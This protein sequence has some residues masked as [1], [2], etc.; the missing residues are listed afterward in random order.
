MTIEFSTT[1]VSSFSGN[2]IEGSFTRGVEF[3]QSVI[4][5]VPST[6]T[7]DFTITSISVVLIGE[8]DPITIAV[9]EPT[10][11]FEGTYLSGWDDVF[12][13]VPPGESN[14][15]TTPTNATID[16]LPD[17]QDLYNLN[18]DQKQFIARNYDVTATYI[19]SVSQ[20]EITETETLTH[21]VFNDI[22]SIRSFM[23]NYDYGEG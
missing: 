14:K 15:T 1:T 6:E 9:D 22:E 20:E 13:Y 8:Q 17:G 5:S 21:E 2:E 10:I 3:T 19:G 12:T 11:N 7:E 18:Q 23:A 16:E 4:V